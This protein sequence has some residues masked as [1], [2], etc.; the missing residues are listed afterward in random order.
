MRTARGQSSALVLV[1]VAGLVAIAAQEQI[2]PWEAANAV[3]PLPHSPLGIDSKLT[4]LTKARN[5][6]GAFK[7]PTL[8]EVS[9]HPP[10][11]HDGALKTLRDVVQ[12]YNKG[13][14]KN[15]YLDP[16]VQP[17]NLT[18]EDISALGKFME[19]LEGE[20]YQDTPPAAF[21]GIRPPS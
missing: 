19:A 11:M 14:N 6:R 2:P 15:P 21:P 8:R 18:E 16:K 12:H 5:D 4:D 1:A 13:G 10:Y 20:G 7:T 17:L 9:L 3:R